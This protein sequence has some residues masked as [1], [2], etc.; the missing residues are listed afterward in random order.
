MNWLCHGGCLLLQGGKTE[1]IEHGVILALIVCAILALKTLY[2]KRIGRGKRLSRLIRRE[3]K[4]VYRL[5]LWDRLY[6]LVHDCYYPPQALQLVLPLVCVWWG[7]LSWLR[8]T[9]TTATLQL[10]TRLQQ[11]EVGI[12]LVFVPLMIFA[13]G[14][15]ARRSVSG[16]NIAEVLLAETYLFPIAIFILGLLGAFILLSTPL[17][18]QLSILVT[19]T[20]ASFVL[21]RLCKTLLDDYY[22]HSAAVRLL[23]DKIRRSIGTTVDARLGHS[24][25]LSELSDTNIVYNPLHGALE[26]TV[27]IPSAK[28]GTITDIDIDKLISFSKAMAIAAEEADVSFAARRERFPF[29]GSSN[30]APSLPQGRRLTQEKPPCL[31]LMFGDD[32]TDSTAILMAFPRRAVRDEKVRRRLSKLAREAF[33]IKQ[34]ESYS[35]RVRKYMR[36]VKDEAILAIKDQRTAQLEDLLNVYVSVGETFLD[37]MKK[38]GGYNFKSAQRERQSLFGRWAELEWITRDLRE[39][40]RRGCLSSEI[41]VVRL[42]TSIPEKLAHL[43]IRYG[44]HLVFDEITSFALYECYLRDEAG[45]AKIKKFLT[46]HALRSLQDLAN[47]GIVIELRRPNT[48]IGSIELIGSLVTVLLLR[49]QYLLKMELTPEQLETFRECMRAV[50]GLLG[51]LVRRGES[52]T[53]G[54]MDSMLEEDRTS[55][56]QALE[57]KKAL[58]EVAR[59]VEMQKQQMLF[60]VGSLILDK[61]LPLDAQGLEPFIAEVDLHLS[62]ADLT[63]LYL[64]MCQPEMADL[65]GNQLLDYPPGGGAVGSAH[66]MF[67]RYY[68]FLLLKSVQNFNEASFGELRVPSTPD[69]VLELSDHGAVRN[70]LSLFETNRDEWRLVVPDEWLTRLPNLIALFDSLIAE[71]WRKDEDRLID[72]KIEATYLN[73]FEQKFVQTF[74]QEAGLRRLFEQFQA[75]VLPPVDGCTQTQVPRWGANMVDNRESY[76]DGPRRASV[77]WPEEYARDLSLSESEKAFHDILAL[78]P[79]STHAQ[80]G[81][82]GSERI[83]NLEAEL[84]EGG[85]G[86]DVLLVGGDCSFFY[87]DEWAHL[88]VPDWSMTATKLSG[89]PGFQGILKLKKSEVP[90]FQVR[91]NQDA[92]SSCLLSFRNGISWHQYLPFESEAE[93]EYLQNFFFFRIIDLAAEKAIREKI[94]LDDPAW[95][96]DVQDKDRYL[97][98]RMWL[99]VL[100]RFEIV[101]SGSLPGLRF[102]LVP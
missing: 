42:V 23:Q 31:M 69:L 1:H 81:V 68:S 93:Q 101:S 4:S 77:H 24:L 34:R 54:T 30:E 37:E 38:L 91:T 21:Y 44:D 71:Q 47:Y 90:I 87:T 2:S 83:A 16:L 86:P 62:P 80:N 72:A 78:I 29:L 7:T 13:V 27:F 95:L 61:V 12:A 75:Y 70:A 46:E 5:R 8:V 88:F 28:K 97:Q 64:E 32:V 96:R 56:Q 36:A 48:E 45:D 51:N 9:P 79:E 57:R 18:A 26:D 53:I 60:S 35:Q 84:E 73:Q 85:T 39:L 17:E 19:L 41:N 25:L 65:W 98:Q 50:G 40:H 76:V 22:L 14:L 33:V 58:Q 89:V 10:I 100:E 11:L 102:R 6:E 20:C 66:E 63:R 49:F 82:V 94:I 3:R 59:T 52:A 92:G 15:S 67:A 99:R 55:I 74:T 43:A